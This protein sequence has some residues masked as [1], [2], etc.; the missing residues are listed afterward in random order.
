[1]I[2]GALIIP[3]TV[4]VVLLVFFRKNV[5]W[6]EYLIT[7]GIP[8]VLIFLF[9]ITAETSVTDDIEYWGGAITQ[10][11]Y[12]EDWDEEV[13]CRHPIPCSHPRY[14]TDSKGNRS[15]AG[16]EHSNDGH[17][18]AYDV[19]YHPEYWT[20]S[21]SNGEGM[22]ISKDRYN[23]L[24][25]KF[26]NSIFVELRRDYHSNDGDMY[27]SRWDGTDNRLE[28]IT[29]LHHYEN[30]VQ[31]ASSVYNYQEV[32]DPKKEG[33]FE[34]PKINGYECL[35]ILGNAGPQTKEASY[36]LNF[37]N[38]KLGKTKQVRIWILVFQN[39]PFETAQR[40]EAYWKGGNKNEF[41]LTVSI[42][43]ARKVQWAH[44][45]SWTPEERLKI[46]TRNYVSEL[47][48]L[49][50]VKVANWVGQ[51]CAIQYKRK[52]F[53]E[54]SY[55]TVDPP[56]WAVVTTYIVTLLSSIGLAYFSIKNEIDVDD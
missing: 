15:F 14:T 8:A 56:T 39:R 26:A 10:V 29:T 34:Y 6:W 32:E 13:P 5:V 41:V 9:K 44:V 40:Q 35:P 23:Y 20:L 38:G 18:H 22:H 16:Y 1:M 37:W 28:T 21:G 27:V 24:K 42:D 52:E 12:Y 7:L 46:E 4:I 45:F 30:R 36:I 31:A 49:D 55:L 47:D 19:D 17:Y 43:A 33:L 25:T 54:F 51:Q 3:V 48:T 2:L 11:S 53:K 50:I